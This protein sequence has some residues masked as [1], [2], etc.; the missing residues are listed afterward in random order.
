MI[1]ILNWVHLILCGLYG[2]FSCINLYD[3]D[4]LIVGKDAPRMGVSSSC[5]GPVD[6]RGKTQVRFKQCSGTSP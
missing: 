1:S 4:K 6:V 5:Y 3:P 2:A